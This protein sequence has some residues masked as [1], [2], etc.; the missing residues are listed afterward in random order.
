MRDLGFDFDFGFD[1]SCEGMS[2]GTQRVWGM[3]AKRRDFIVAL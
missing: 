2:L 1:L 3:R